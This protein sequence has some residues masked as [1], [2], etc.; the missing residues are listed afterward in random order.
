METDKIA[1]KATPIHAVLLIGSEALLTSPDEV[2][3]DA[4]WMVLCLTDFTLTNI[5]FHYTLLH[6]YFLISG[7][8][9]ME[10]RLNITFTM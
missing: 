10:H 4:N 6:V 8:D 5:G 2:T 3:N 9:L 1:S 7:I